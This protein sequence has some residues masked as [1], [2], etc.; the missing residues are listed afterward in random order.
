MSQRDVLS[1]T[2]R[3]LVNLAP[4]ELELFL[5]SD[6]AKALGPESPAEG[7]VV[8]RL[9]RTPKEQLSDEDVATLSRVVDD[10]KARRADRPDGD[11]QQ[12]AWRLELMSR[13]H[14]PL[15]WSAGPTPAAAI[16]GPSRGPRTVERG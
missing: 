16:A 10:I 2:F 6:A 12:S 1:A 8:I 9:L 15:T 5:D 4:R 7:R 11:V 3:N 13:G 14:D